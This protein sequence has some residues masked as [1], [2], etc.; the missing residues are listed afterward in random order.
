METSSFV[1]STE[2]R[3]HVDF[4]LKEELGEIHVNIPEF[5]DTYF[6]NIPQLTA[7]SQALLKGCKRG[8]NSLYS[9]EKGCRGWPELVTEKDVLGW[10][11]NII[12]ELVQLAEAQELSWKIDC[13]PLTQPSQLL[14]RSIAER[15]LDIGFVDD[16]MITEDFRCHWSQ[17]LVSGELKNDLKYDRKSRA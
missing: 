3:K 2:Y 12:A 14:Q 13:R 1:N 7:A 5:F 16:S 15:K 4:V 6:G 17:I 10:L 8:D 11:A 9:E